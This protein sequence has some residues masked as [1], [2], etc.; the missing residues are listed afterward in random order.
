MITIKLMDEEKNRIISIKPTN[1]G[2]LLITYF[3]G[4]QKTIEVFDAPGSSSIEESSPILEGKSELFCPHCREEL[5]DCYHFVYFSKIVKDK[6]YSFDS[7]EWKEEVVSRVCSKCLISLR[8][9][10]LEEL[11]IEYIVVNEEAEGLKGT[12]RMEPVTC[13]PGNCPG[14][15]KAAWNTCSIEL[16][17]ASYPNCLKTLKCEEDW[18]IEKDGSK[19]TLSNLTKPDNIDK[20]LE[21]PDKYDV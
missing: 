9:W 10:E 12:L 4:T 5:I 1:P 2:F 8:E 18:R 3:D 16:N 13:T 7:S 20:I 6:V 19:I 15:K 11:F 14:I 21:N 17:C